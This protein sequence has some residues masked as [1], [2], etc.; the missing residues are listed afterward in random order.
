[1]DRAKATLKYAMTIAVSFGIVVSIILQFIPN[2]AVSIFTNDATVISM[3][4]EYLRG[5][6]WDCALA[7]VHFCFSGFFTACGL[8][9]ISFAH[10]FTSIIT[11]RIPLAYLASTNF[12][13]TLYPMGL[14]T[15]TG[16]L[17]SVIICLFAYRWLNKKHRLA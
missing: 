2:A 8:S 7:G 3:G 1:M 10:N 13:D 5:Y 11:A 12:P 4:G 16:S 14:A 6:T 9:T 17:V 15:V